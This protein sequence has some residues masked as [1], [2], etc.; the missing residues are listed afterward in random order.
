MLPTLTKYKLIK[1]SF[2]KSTKSFDFIKQSLTARKRDY[3][4]QKKT[5]LK[6]TPVLYL[7][8]NFSFVDKIL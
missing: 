8:H 4:Q 6:P 5:S 1:T 3:K 2:K 7:H